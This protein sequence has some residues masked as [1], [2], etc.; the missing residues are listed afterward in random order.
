GF[1]RV[2]NNRA[3]IGAYE[4][5]P[6]ATQITLVSSSNPSQAGQSVTFTATVTTGVPGSNA[7]QG[8]VT[9]LN[10]GVPIATVALVNGVASVSI[11][12]LLF[13]TRKITAQYS[14]FQV[15]DYVFNPSQL[16]TPFLQTV[17][18]PGAYFGPI[19]VY[20]TD[21][22]VPGEVRVFNATTLDL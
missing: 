20:G 15:G 6:P 18:L 4:Y 14:G 12:T 17:S 3:D 13:G 8:T 10:G 11:S 16:A 19:L 1:N 5:Q 9:F 21:A 2:I 7:P 22:G